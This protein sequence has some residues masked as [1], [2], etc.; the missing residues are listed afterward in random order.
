[1]LWPRISA[2]FERYG[3]RVI[4][5]SI[6]PWYFIPPFPEKRDLRSTTP[7]GHH[8]HSR[9]LTARRERGDRD[10][11][12]RE[13]RGRGSAGRERERSSTARA[14]CLRDFSAELRSGISD[15][16]QGRT[17]TSQA[18]HSSLFLAASCEVACPVYY[19]PFPPRLGVTQFYRRLYSYPAI[20]IRCYGPASPPFLNATA[21]ALSFFP[22]SPEVRETG[23][24]IYNTKRPPPPLAAAHGEERERGERCGEEREKRERQC[25]ERERSSTARTS[26]LR[27]FSA[28]L[29]SGISDERQGSVTNLFTYKS[30]VILELTGPIFV[31]VPRMVYLPSL[32]FLILGCMVYSNEKSLHQLLSHCPVLEDL[33]LERNNEDNNCPFTLSVI[34]PSLQRLTLKISRGY[35]F[36]GLVINTPSLKYFKILDYLEEYALLRDDNSNYSYY[37]EDTPKLEEADIESTYPDI[38]KFVRSIRSV[39]RLSLCIRVNAD[40]EALYHE[41]IVFDQLQHLKL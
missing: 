10:A 5:L 9:L 18:D 20:F 27:D 15:E 34:V 6:L 38:N 37:F 19:D 41:H 25:G 1:M 33:V 39:K 35:H 26:C 11:V 22:P 30:L 31:N 4:F 40:E 23:S 12:R 32:K 7:S 24:E 28:E 8:H 13:K 2:V 16:R 29:R 3:R 36:E 14:S 21:A 17:Y